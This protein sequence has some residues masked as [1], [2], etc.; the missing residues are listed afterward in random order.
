MRGLD[1]VVCCLFVCL[2]V[3]SFV[4]LLLFYF[5]V[6][7]VFAD[8]EP[9]VLQ[10]L[11]LEAGVSL[12]HNDSES[13]MRPTTPIDEADNENSDAEEED[14]PGIGSSASTGSRD[15]LDK[16]GADYTYDIE[17]ARRSSIASTWSGLSGVCKCGPRP[18]QQSL[19][20]SVCVGA[21]VGACVCSGV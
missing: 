12:L 11:V 10:Q 6:A 17:T 3:R 1:C 7:G 15:D 21:C 16:Y 19:D 5:G 8:V 18:E 13:S 9:E 14:D 4:C 20:A 2:F